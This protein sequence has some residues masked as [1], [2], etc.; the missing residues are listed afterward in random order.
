MK[1]VA[2]TMRQDIV[3]DGQELRDGLDV[4]WHQFLGSCGACALLLPN[5]LATAARL[6]EECDPT[7]FLL[8]GGGDI[9]SISGVRGARDDIEALIVDIARRRRKPIVGICRGLQVLMADDGAS[10]HRVFGHTNIN[11]PVCGTIGPREVNSF[12]DYGANS[13][14]RNYEILA[15]AS[16]GTIEMARHAELPWLGVGWH[17]ERQSSFHPEDIL[18]VRSILEGERGP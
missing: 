17:P 15:R 16:D 13:L 2:C 18:W 9:C 1:L 11:H 3:S 6:I 14:S 8:T 5:H 7:A 10:I 12:H 4:S